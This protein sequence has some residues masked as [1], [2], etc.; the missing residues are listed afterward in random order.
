MRYASPRVVLLVTVL[1]SFRPVHSAINGALAPDQ[2]ALRVMISMAVAWVLVGVLTAVSRSFL[3]QHERESN[4]TPD[5]Q[6]PEES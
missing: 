2:A 5:G 3:M 1:F 4:G 6:S